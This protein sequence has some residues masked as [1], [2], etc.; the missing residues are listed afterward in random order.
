MK[1]NKEKFEIAMASVPITLAQLSE[2]SEISVVAIR[3]AIN[4]K[5][6]PKPF[7]VGKLAKAL[8]VPVEEII[9]REEA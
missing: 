7:T 5:R 1:I 8:N 3:K 2:K 6:N 9:L 4:G